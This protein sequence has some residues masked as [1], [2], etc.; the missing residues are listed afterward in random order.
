MP[1][2]ETNG[3]TVAYEQQ[4][5]GPDLVLVTGVGYGGWFWH[6]VVPGLAAHFT[7]TTFDN[8][9]AGGSSQP[10]GP[11]TVEM[12]A[13]DTAGLLDALGIQN[14]AVLG[15]SLGG[16]IVQQMVAARPE[17]AG[18]VI[19]SGTN[20]GGL[21]VIP[22]TP[23]ALSVLTNRVGDPLD[24]IRRGIVVATA[25]GFSEKQPAVVEELI[26]YR[27]TNP[28]PPAQ[29][30]AQVMAGAGTAQWGDSR[31]NEQ[32]AAIRVPCLILF[33]EQDRVV[34]PANAQLMATKIPQAQVKILPNTGH[35]F[36]IENPQATTAALLQFL[37]E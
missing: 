4:G 2:I 33:G 25:P 36:P 5:R 27:L 37:R 1:T 8:R 16:Y 18:R 10:A 7:V 20:H 22:I 26:A 14:A 35:L 19:L 15:H 3:I 13:A 21:K 34:P 24:L 11:Y 30:T 31:I 6:K 9:G 28:V 29:Y 23:E 32:M 12:L 17:L